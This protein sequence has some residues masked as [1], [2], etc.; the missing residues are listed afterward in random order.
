MFSSL[1]SSFL[2]VASCFASFSIH[3]ESLGKKTYRFDKKARAL[4]FKKP[5]SQTISA[6]IQHQERETL[7]FE[8]VES[9]HVDLKNT[10]CQVRVVKHNKQTVE[11]SHDKNLAIVH[12]QEGN[13]LGLSVAQ[14][15]ER[16]VKVTQQE[17]LAIIIRIPEKTQVFFYNQKMS[18]FQKQTAETKQIVAR[19]SMNRQRNKN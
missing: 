6:G 5:V 10:P 15:T 4:E 8:S 16:T 1:I 17:R 3:A 7:R 13:I 14:K 12:Q 19:S 11:I 18:V 9:L 2:V